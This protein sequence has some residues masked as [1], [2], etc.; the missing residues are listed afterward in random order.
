MF[1]LFLIDFKG[2]NFCFCLCMHVCS[3]FSQQL[4]GGFKRN[5]LYDNSTTPEQCYKYAT[6]FY[7][8]CLKRITHMYI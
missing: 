5:F 6:F 4:L 8:D 3:Q 2:R 1:S 7:S